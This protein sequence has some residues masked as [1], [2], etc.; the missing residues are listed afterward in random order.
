MRKLLSDIRRVKFLDSLKLL[1]L[2]EYVI[3][4]SAVPV[5]WG[6]MP[7]NHDL[8]VVVP[9]DVWIDLCVRRASRW[10]NRLKRRREIWFGK[11]HILE[12]TNL[13][14]NYWD[15]WKHSEMIGGARFLTLWYALSQNPKYS[16]LLE[17]KHDDVHGSYR[18]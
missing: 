9:R 10:A 15:D 18:P 14:W 2:S 17:V 7:D 1:K 5:L 11:V 13:R 8:D 16:L 4:G 12:P 3:V 6:L